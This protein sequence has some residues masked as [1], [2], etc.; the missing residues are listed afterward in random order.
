MKS[1]ISL[2]SVAAGLLLCIVAA[3]LWR[4]TITDSLTTDEKAHIPA[5]ITYLTDRSMALNPEHPPL[6]KLISGASI[7]SFVKLDLPSLKETTDQGVNRQYEHGDLLLARNLGQHDAIIHY[8]R[9]PF[10]LL[11]VFFCFLVYRY[12]RNRYDEITG[13]LGLTLVAFSPT[14]ISHGHLVTFDVA[15]AF[16]YFI[17]ILSFAAFL[18]KPSKRSVAIAGFSL[19]IALLVKF[20]ALLLLPIFFISLVVWVFI[21][22]PSN[23]WKIVGQSGLVLLIAGLSVYIVYFILT[24]GYS[25]ADNR[26]DAIELTKYHRIQSIMRPAAE[27]A[28]YRITQPIGHYMLGALQTAARSR[29]GNSSYFM[30]KVENYGTPAYF[31]VLFLTKE[32]LPAIAIVIWAVIH[33]LVY[34]AWKREKLNW[35]Q[36]IEQNPTESIM[37]LTVVLY[38]ALALASP[39]NIGYRHILP[40]IPLIFLLA[41]VAM[42]SWVSPT[43]RRYQLIV[44]GLLGIWAVAEP[45]VHYPNLLN[46]YNQIVGGEARGYEV[47]VDSNYDWGQD[48]ARL[49]S[50]VKEKNIDNIAI[51]YF[52]GDSI[53]YYFGDHYETWRSSYGPPVGWFAISA[54]VRQ[55]AME[56]HSNDL[57][58][59]QI[60]TYWWLRDVPPVERIGSLFI[61]HFE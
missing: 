19:A 13:L 34:L 46:Y 40:T 16:G 50:Y 3:V 38:W 27:L 26:R 58:I 52:G 14:I 28:G 57:P 37:I 24:I 47:S 25:P 45:L 35:R 60:D 11:T 17:A 18:N 39:L 29:N 20:S 8:G 21:K 54:T 42:R 23:M 9:L 12:L 4:L 10:V 48:L 33:V 44:V 53:D 22:R 43:S 59:S 56:P 49:A 7:L 15:A 32:S 31:P 5:G 55:N 51:D 30:G 1:K 41:S 36:L 61:Y 6:M 2:A